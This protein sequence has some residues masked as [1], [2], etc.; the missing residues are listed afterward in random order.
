METRAPGFIDLLH[1]RL[2]FREDGWF[3]AREVGGAR[4][5]SASQWIAAGDRTS[6]GS[7]SLLTAGKAKLNEERVKL[8][9][10]RKGGAT[11][12]WAA[13]SEGEVLPL[14]TRKDLLSSTKFLDRASR[15]SWR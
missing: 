11:V 12:E 4:P 8:K 15:P 6:R 5:L 10:S 13:A 3:Q 7:R 14:I 1:E 2:L 9:N